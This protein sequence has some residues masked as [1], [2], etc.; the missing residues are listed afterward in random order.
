MK[1][2]KVWQILVA[3]LVITFG[4]YGS[5]KIYCGAND[6]YLD[7][8]HDKNSISGISITQYVKGLFLM[9]TQ[10]S[11]YHDIANSINVNTTYHLYR[12]YLDNFTINTGR[13]WK[14][15]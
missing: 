10:D 11:K 8:R 4:L 13:I 3:V 1:K 15:S 12:D 2:V 9:N 6:R 14:W 5:W 7:D